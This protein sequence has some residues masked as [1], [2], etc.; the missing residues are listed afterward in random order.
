MNRAREAVCMPQTHKQSR[1]QTCTY[2]TEEPMSR[3]LAP[4][5]EGSYFS[6]NKG[7]ST[8]PNVQLWKSKTPRAD[9]LLVKL[10]LPNREINKNF[11]LSQASGHIYREGSR[12]EG[13]GYTPD[14][15]FIFLLDTKVNTF[16]QI[17][18]QIRLRKQDLNLRGCQSLNQYPSF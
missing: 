3:G 18:I 17:K 2:Q 11:Q 1:I 6:R 10:A 9:E 5:I 4:S 13:E 7:R 16:D 14:R 12:A 8:Y 15:R